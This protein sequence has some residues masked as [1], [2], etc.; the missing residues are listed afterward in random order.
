MLILAEQIKL[1]G[2]LVTFEFDIATEGASP[3]VE[4]VK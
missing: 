2:I 4:D 1:L 3:Y